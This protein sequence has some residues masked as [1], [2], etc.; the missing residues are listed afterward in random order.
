MLLFYIICSMCAE[1]MKGRKKVVNPDE[2]GSKGRNESGIILP[3]SD[4]KS[5]S[6]NKKSEE[7]ERFF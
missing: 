6:V 7:K 2:V 1:C 4:C 3:Y 5:R